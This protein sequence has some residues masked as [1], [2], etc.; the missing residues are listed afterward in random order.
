MNQ[1]DGMA[2]IGSIGS[3][4][5]LITAI[6]AFCIP[7]FIYRIRN[8]VIKMRLQLDNIASLL[9]ERPIVEKHPQTITDE[10]WLED[11]IKCNNCGYMNVAGF[12]KCFRCGEKLG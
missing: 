4:L 11:A 8:E 7:F 9:N 5:L 2:A 10:E 6:L 3:I 1:F 12:T